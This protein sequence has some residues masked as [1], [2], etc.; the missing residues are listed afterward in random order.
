MKLMRLLVITL[1]FAFIFGGIVG[2]ADAG[3]KN[4]VGSMDV[5]EYMQENEKPFTEELRVKLRELEEKYPRLEEV[6]KKVQ[7]MWE[8]VKRSDALA[9]EISSLGDDEAVDK[10]K[11]LDELNKVFWTR[12]KEEW[13]GPKSLLYAR[14]AKIT[15]EYN[16]YKQQLSDDQGNQLTKDL[17]KEA[18]LEAKQKGYSMVLGFVGTGKIGPVYS[19][20]FNTM[21]VEAIN[22]K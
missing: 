10:K 4:K 20:L 16:E 21:D 6:E 22:I 15:A 5:P 18:R 12:M 2:M 7:P 11:E 14:S 17:K 13:E 3:K 9:A 19:I 1:S 8:M